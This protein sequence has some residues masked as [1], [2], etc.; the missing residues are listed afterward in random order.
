MHFIINI[1]INAKD[2]T[3]KEIYVYFNNVSHIP[4]QLAMLMHEQYF[5]FIVT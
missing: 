4:S 1:Q 3:K 2:A 5:V